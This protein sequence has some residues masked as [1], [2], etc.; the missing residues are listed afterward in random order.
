MVKNLPASVG[1][2][3][4]VGS[5][6]GWGKSPGGGHSN[7]LQYSCLENLIDRG[8]WQAAIQRVAQNHTQLSNLACI[9]AQCAKTPSEVVF[10]ERCPGEAKSLEM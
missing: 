6:L 5:I 1:D 4:D 9:H 3:R 8:A 7:P 10:E 2:M